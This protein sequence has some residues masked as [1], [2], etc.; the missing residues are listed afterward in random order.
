VP[1]FSLSIVKTSSYSN[2]TK[3]CHFPGINECFLRPIDNR[4]IILRT[5]KSMKR[6]EFVK[7]ISMGPIERDT[8]GFTM[9]C[10]KGLSIKINP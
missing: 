1:T 8:R 6:E 5:V 9:N 3:D 7:E 4:K 10:V 2:S